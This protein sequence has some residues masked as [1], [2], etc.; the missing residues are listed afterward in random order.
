MIV[1]IMIQTNLFVQ[2]LKKEN[3][4]K[5]IFL[6][7]LYT[8]V[9]LL[10]VILIVWLGDFF[11]VYLIL[12]LASAIGLF[13]A[14][15]TL[16]SINWTINSLRRKIR[17]GIYPGREFVNIAGIII[18]GILLITP[19]FVTGFLGFLLFLPFLRTSVGRFITRKLDPTFKEIYEYM[20]LEEL[21]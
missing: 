16:L 6:F 5:M 9:P 7:L 13:G 10:E 1:I 4:F 3:V 19:G 20:K 11:G 2:L 17:E 14:A 12:G 18:R 21:K 15:V 8:I